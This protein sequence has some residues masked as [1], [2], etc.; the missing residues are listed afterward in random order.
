MEAIA[1]L[2]KLAEREAVHLR[3]IRDIAV[4]DATLVSAKH[5]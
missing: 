5:A 4:S 1:P 3:T 2:V